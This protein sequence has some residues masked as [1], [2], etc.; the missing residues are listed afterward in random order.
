[1]VSVV[2]NLLTSKRLSCYPSATMSVKSTVLDGEML[3]VR[4][5]HQP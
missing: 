1:M 5:Q 4:Q 3:D 2:T